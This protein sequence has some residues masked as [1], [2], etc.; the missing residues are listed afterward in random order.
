MTAEAQIQDVYIQM[1]HAMVQ[2]DRKTLELLH[3]D[4]FILTHMTGTQ[5]NKQEY[6]DSIMDGTFNYYSATHENMNVTLSGDRV[7]MD[8]Q[9]LVNAAVYGGGR[10]TWHLR[11]KIEF[12]QRN[13]NWKILSAKATTY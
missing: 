12:I 9:S 8:G 3:D 7:I 1:Y 10:H 13:G 4:N 2:K 6:I 5:Q 11:L